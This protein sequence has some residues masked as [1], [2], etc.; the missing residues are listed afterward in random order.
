MIIGLAVLVIM[1]AIYAFLLRFKLGYVNTQNAKLIELHR[2][3]IAE[4]NE[5]VDK[6][7]ALFI[8]NAEDLKSA[9]AFATEMGNEFAE[10]EFKYNKL[11]ESGGKKIIDD[12]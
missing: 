3:A 5:V 8:R 1:L 7:N 6:Y 9:H 4:G 2:N 12:P 10:L 11:M